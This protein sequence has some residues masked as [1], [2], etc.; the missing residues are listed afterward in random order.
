MKHSIH[1]RCQKGAA[2][3]LTAMV[4]MTSITVI[5]LAVARTQLVEQRI[6]NNDSWITRLGLDA[7]TGIAEATDHTNK[8]LYG[9]AWSG[10]ATTGAQRH[11]IKPAQTDSAVTRTQMLL[12]TSPS[13]RY[14]Q[15]V[16]KTE[17]NDGSGLRA[18]ASQFIRPLTALT[19]FAEDA[20][21]LI[22]NGCLTG[23]PRMLQLW[24]FSADT[25]QAGKAML[26]LRGSGCTAPANSDFHKGLIERRKLSGDLWSLV[27][28][29][30]RERFK[31][32]SDQHRRLPQN[33]RRY[34]QVE[35]SD[36][37]SGRW[38]RSL[39]T[40]QAPVAI[41]FPAAVGCPRFSPGLRLYGI[42]F[43]DGACRRPLASRNTSVYGS[44]V[45]NGPIDITGSELQVRHISVESAQFRYL[46][47]PVLR[48]IAVP[49]TW[50]DF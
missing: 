3:L 11:S 36:M 31:S 29:I 26:T 12:R 15:V 20:P 4:L 39:G 48:S 23:T 49:G 32:L 22:I 6:L 47:F 30:E 17:R 35:K 33:Q 10:S 27:F 5:T 25:G 50:A 42:V 40:A 46:R 9:I 19:P 1:G 44:L 21:P 37:L 41:Y 7:E 43:I 38:T 45:A 34:W 8:Q 2:T 18:V 24:P 28:S 14:I 16:A 13:E